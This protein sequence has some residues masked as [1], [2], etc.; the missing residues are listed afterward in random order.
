M[1]LRLQN[2]YNIHGCFEIIESDSFFISRTNHDIHFINKTTL[3]IENTINIGEDKVFGYK[4]MGTKNDLC[5]AIVH[6]HYNKEEDKLEFGDAGV[7]CLIAYSTKGREWIHQFKSWTIGANY[8]GL[9]ILDN[10]ILIN[11]EEEEEE[12]TKTFLLDFKTG[13]II[14][15]I[16]NNERFK[17]SHKSIVGS[18]IAISF[19]NKVLIA[20]IDEKIIKLEAK[21]NKI[22]RTKLFEFDTEVINQTDEYIY[23]YGWDE[24]YKLLKLDK[25]TCKIVE[26]ISFD[27][28]LKLIDISPTNDNQ[29][30]IYNHEKTYNVSKLDLKTKDI[31]WTIGEDKKDKAYQLILDEQNNILVYFHLLKNSKFEILNHLDGEVIYQLD[32]QEGKLRYPFFKFGNKLFIQE[33][34]NLYLYDIKN[35]K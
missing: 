32:S 24:G 34:N 30:I 29:S 4:L 6:A 27:N 33:W 11:D 7:A 10:Y 35:L 28:D 18:N 19:E 1:D 31:I 21:N 20:T 12:T 23:I 25:S 13:N 17:H 14:S 8:G 3:E 15:E 9:F 2:K 16:N 5:Y 26:T 22:I